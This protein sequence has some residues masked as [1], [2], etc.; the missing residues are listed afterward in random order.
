MNSSM[1]RGVRM[2]CQ[3]LDGCEQ[4]SKGVRGGVENDKVHIF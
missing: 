3:K 1:A 4:R 2:L